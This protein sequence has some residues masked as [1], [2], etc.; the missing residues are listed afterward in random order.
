MPTGH[1][2]LQSIFT[3]RLSPRKLSKLAVAE[4]GLP[5][6]IILQEHA[7]AGQTAA[8]RTTMIAP[9]S[10]CRKSPIALASHRHSLLPHVH[11]DLKRRFIGKENMWTAQW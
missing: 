10:A 8:A 3:D 2:E 11:Q 1:K 5:V 6:G 4:P 7:E 9:S